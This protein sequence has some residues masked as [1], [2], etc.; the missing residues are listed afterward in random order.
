MFL[1]RGERLF[2]LN[3]SPQRHRDAEPVI[4]LSQCFVSKNVGEYRD[5][6]FLNNQK[7]LHSKL[8]LFFPFCILSPVFCILFNLHHRGHREKQ[9]I[10]KN[11]QFFLLLHF[12][13]TVTDY[14][15]IFFRVSRTCHGWTQ[16]VFLF[17]VT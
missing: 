11:C 10:F 12:F 7:N 6:P 16:Q 5:T 2:A 8:F 1:C 3:I 4:T 15:L 13:N 14:S 17:M 9:R